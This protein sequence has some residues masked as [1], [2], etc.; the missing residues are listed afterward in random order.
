M[1]YYELKVAL[2]PNDEISRDILAA[3]LADI[4]FESFMETDDGLADRKSTRLN[5]SH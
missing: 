5:S 1:N 4:G 3:L 2:S